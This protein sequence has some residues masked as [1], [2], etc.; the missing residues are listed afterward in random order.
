MKLPQEG[1]NDMT[2]KS[3]IELNKYGLSNCDRVSKGVIGGLRGLGYRNMGIF[4]KAT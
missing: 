3:A 4:T 2:F 1:E